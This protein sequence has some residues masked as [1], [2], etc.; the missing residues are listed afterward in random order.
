MELDYLKKLNSELERSIINQEKI[1]FSQDELIQMLKL[2]N[3][4]G[5]KVSSSSNIDASSSLK[6]SPND[7]LFATVVAQQTILSKYTN[8]NGANLPLSPGWQQ[9]CNRTRKSNVVVGSNKNNTGQ[10]TF[11][12]RGVC[13]RFHINLMC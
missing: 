7:G 10:H 5:N 11:W 9:V 13:S 12:C 4:N 6:S 1:V 2:N 3:N 8:P